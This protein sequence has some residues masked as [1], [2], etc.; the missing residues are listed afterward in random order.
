MK[1]LLV[2]S[3]CLLLAPLTIFCAL[4]APPPRSLTLNEA[5]RI[6]V[7]NNLDVRAE[8]YNPAQFEADI[9]R[10]RAIYAP[11]ITAQ[12]GVADTTEA[13]PRA[14]GRIIDA[15]SHI[16]DTS[17]S[18]LFPTGATAALSLS[19]AYNDNNSP[20]LLHPYW[21]TGL[22]LTLN[23]PLL[24]NRGRE[25]TEENIRISQLSKYASL[26]RFK[27]RLLT[28]V[29]QVR[30]DYFKLY[31]LR[32]E[33]GVR[34]VSLELAKTILTETRARVAAG[35]LP[36]L[37]ILNAEFGAIT[38]EKE[39]NDAEK[40]V[41]DQVDILRLLLQLDGG[42]DIATT[43]VPS[44]ECYEISEAAAIDRSLTRPDLLEQQ[45]HLELAEFQT[46]VLNNKRQPD[47]SL[48]TS[49][50]VNAIDRDRVFNDGDREAFDH[51]NWSVGLVISY[52]LGNEAA[53]NEFRKSRLK[54]EQTRIQ[55]KSLQETAA[56]E[57][58][59]A[60]RGI[61]S[62][63]KQ[64]EVSDRG[65]AFADKRLHAFI[66]KNE[67][68]LATTKEVLDVETELAAAKS[69]RI[70]AL[71]LYADSLTRL[72]QVTGELLEHQGILVDESDANRLY[73]GRAMK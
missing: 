27:T 70:A 49:A 52:P 58:R 67:A 33:L 6:A 47:L 53:E 46:R 43:D 19:N 55:I 41:S 7:E 54:S 50:G 66:R 11:R 63:F 14:D 34:Q 68:G 57:V 24:K 29:A 3:L 2:F 71:V 64:I 13:Q 56:N 59:A 1:P 31:R 5:V 18:Q 60:V 26:E 17:V 48:Q 16:L 51:F 40:A 15:R 20:S 62:S 4:A 23:Q 35:V 45:Q 73:E 44:P 28:T 38:R 30:Y 8:L 22:A 9:R 65:V 39:L 61:G 32:E 25:V 69:N 12:T 21:V 10:Y 72:W 36:A 37:E 42:I